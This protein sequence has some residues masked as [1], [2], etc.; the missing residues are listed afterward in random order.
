MKFCVMKRAQGDA[1]FNLGLPV[2]VQR[3]RKHVMGV[4]MLACL[5]QSA[6][7]VPTDDCP[8]PTPPLGRLPK[9]RGRPAVHEVRVACSLVPLGDG[10]GLSAPSGAT[11]GAGRAVSSAVQVCL[12]LS[13]ASLAGNRTDMLVEQRF[14][15]HVQLTLE[16]PHRAGVSSQVGSGLGV[17]HERPSGLGQHRFP[18]G[19]A[20][21]RTPFDGAQR[22]KPATP[23]ALRS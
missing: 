23:A 16:A 7:T 14:V 20:A 10:L 17:R 11:L 9:R 5:T 22:T 1:V 6:N 12:D 13:P 18:G 19:A 8:C 15:E 2:V 4:Q 21:I 3:D